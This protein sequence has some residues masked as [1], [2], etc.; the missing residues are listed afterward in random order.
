MN[1]PE[2]FRYTKEH[3]WVAVTDGV[4]TVTGGATPAW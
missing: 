3:E 2:N 4:P 1:Y